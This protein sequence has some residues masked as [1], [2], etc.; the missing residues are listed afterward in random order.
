MSS[1]LF[2]KQDNSFQ[3]LFSSAQAGLAQPSWPALKLL[4]EGWFT[5]FPPVAYMGP[6]AASVGSQLE[7]DFSPIDFPSNRQWAS[8]K[9]LELGGVF[10]QGA[11]S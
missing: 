7:W 10:P 2:S 8:V 11:I 3:L 4:P 6:S 1:L 9:M 5:A